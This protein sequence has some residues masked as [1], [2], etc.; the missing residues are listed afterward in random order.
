[1]DIFAQYKPLRNKVALLAVDDALGVLWA[2]CQLLQI[3]HFQPPKEIEIADVFLNANPRQSYMAE[4]DI[5]LLAKEVVI[6]A[7]LVATKGRTIRTWKTLA[8]LINGFK[9][10]EQNIY[11]Q[12]GNQGNVLVELIRF[13]HRQII[14]Q[15]NPPNAKSIIRYYKIFNR[16]RIDDLCSGRFGLTVW[17]IYMCGVACMG[18][19]LD[20]PALVNSFKSEIKAL[21]P[22]VVEQF[23]SFVS[24]PLPALGKVLKSEQQYDERFAYA[25]NSLRKYPLIRMN[26]QGRDAI[27]CPLL[28]LLYWK[29][30]SGL[31]YELIDDPRFGNEFGEGFQEY[32]GFVIE[33]ACPNFQR[34]PE[35][36]YKVGKDT[37]RS[38]DWIV[39][40][41]NAALFVECKARRLSLQ[42]KTTLTDISY[43]E[44]DI[45]NL[46]AA[47]VQVYK[48]LKDCLTGVYP[49]YI[50]RAGDQIY[51]A[52][53]TLENW[54][55]MGSVMFD[56]LD[57]SVAQQM[58]K[59]GL[60]QEL[61]TRY[62][63]SVWAVEE[64]EVGLQIM[65]SVGLKSFL[66]GKLANNS[67]SSWDWHGY[68]SKTYTSMYPFNALFDDEYEAMFADL[69][70]AQESGTT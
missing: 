21:P 1:M 10:L 34:L 7:G 31:Y 4:W 61:V 51:P 63:Y 70:S 26:Y 24:L 43:L 41:K 64:L 60:S 33:K 52:V 32:I 13:V 62:P 55:L 38:V 58:K 9:C 42:S 45:E 25:F 53:V 8:E 19:Y 17:Q 2:Y 6:N 44:A 39:A 65:Q 49:H 12:V 22:E 47:V 28:T 46:A 35:K 11:A 16:T 5:E 66:N 40:D 67:F 29:F 15:V 48:T 56:L 30:T 27:V 59:A 68:M 23:L 37:K 3:R 54:R 50:H 18:F 57:R 20:K 14:W 69:Y 36:E